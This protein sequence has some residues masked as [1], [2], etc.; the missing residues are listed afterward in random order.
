MKPDVALTEFQY[1]GQGAI[2]LARKCEKWL[3]GDEENTFVKS[4][5]KSE[6]YLLVYGQLTPAATLLFSKEVE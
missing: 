1:Y 3:R 5:G 4:E 6:L 2:D